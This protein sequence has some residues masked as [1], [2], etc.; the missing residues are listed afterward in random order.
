LLAAGMLSSAIAVY[1]FAVFF[2]LMQGARGPIVVALV[3][4]LYAGGSVGTIFGAMSMA[5]GLGAALG[6]LI[7]GALHEATGTY[8]ASLVMGACGA[9]CGLAVF[10]LVPSLRDEKLA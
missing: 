4:K 9:G 1:A 3:A 7:S 5:M 2:G 8:T 6:S 10:W